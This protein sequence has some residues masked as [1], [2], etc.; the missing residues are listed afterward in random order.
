MVVSLEGNPVPGQN[1]IWDNSCADCSLSSDNPVTD[2]K[3]KAS[4][5]FSSITAGNK[6][7][8]ICL[9]DAPGTCSTPVNIDVLARPELQ[10]KVNKE[11]SWSTGNWN[12]KPLLKEGM[13]DLQVT[14]AGGNVKWT[15][16]SGIAISGTSDTT[17]ATLTAPSNSMEIEY[18]VHSN[19]PKMR[20]T[21]KMTLNGTAVLIPDAAQGLIDYEAA[22]AACQA[23]GANQVAED[24][25]GQVYA[26]W[27]DI[28]KIGA[29]PKIFT[30][31]L[32]GTLGHDPDWPTRTKSMEL[33]S[34]KIGGGFEFNQ[35]EARG[36]C[37]K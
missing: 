37:A 22:R 35:P 31:W 17:T 28:S 27:G 21:Q 32:N 16:S 20:L 19:E 26:T 1:L 10:W 5:T 7:L 11:S 24:T 8:K 25:A 23:I 29:Y 12:S 30:V 4:V 36:F 9:K 14:N 6:T 2:D 33:H 3:G 15:P 34:G 18:E 13:I